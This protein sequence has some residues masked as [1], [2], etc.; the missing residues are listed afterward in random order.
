MLGRF[1]RK[2]VSASVKMRSSFCQ[3]ALKS[4]P[5][6]KEGMEKPYGD[7]E[8]DVHDIGKNT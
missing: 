6:T 1:G 7:R 5:A 3:H 8:G 4:K 2:N